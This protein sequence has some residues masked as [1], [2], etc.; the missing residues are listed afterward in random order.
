M[1]IAR[2]VTSQ[3]CKCCAVTFTPKRAGAQWCSPACRTA[4]YRKREMPIPSTFWYGE[5]KRLSPHISWR[6]KERSAN[7]GHVE[8][9][10]AALADKLVE[11]AATEDGGRPKTGRRFWYLALSHGYVDPDMG[12]SK[13]AKKERDAATDRI[14][15]IL[16]TLRKQG[17]LSWKAVLDLTPDLDTRLTYESPRDARAHM[18]NIYDED[19]WIGQPAFPILI[20]EKD[21]LEPICQPMARSWQMPFASSR[22]YSSLTLQHDV[23]E[24]LRNRHGRTGQRA[25]VYFISDL[26]PSGLDLQR[27]WESALDDFETPIVAFERIGLDLVQVL[28]P[29]LDIARLGI[30]V[31]PGDS[32]TDKFIPD[33]GRTCWEADIL[34]AAEIGAAIDERI[35]S[36][37]NG[38][39]WN[40]RTEEINRARKLL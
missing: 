35:E 25:I 39:L 29:D 40:Q 18:R 15:D 16:G 5:K 28:N 22:G 34:P 24:M 33:Y 17:K 31:K 13:S 1:T 38:R 26:D 9:S 30:G 37:I 6:A 19:R 14:T 32:R 11:L 20:V 2:N 8:L 36:W 23:A 21:T 7:R 4:A 27:A 10:N 12:A 3:T